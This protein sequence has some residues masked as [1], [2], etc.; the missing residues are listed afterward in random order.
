MYYLELVVDSRG[1]KLETAQV[2]TNHVSVG[3]LFGLGCLVKTQ[4]NKVIRCIS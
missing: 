2:S 1:R 3:S 4:I